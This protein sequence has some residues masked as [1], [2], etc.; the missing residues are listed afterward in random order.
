M[1]VKL[2]KCFWRQSRPCPS[3]Q[4]KWINTEAQAACEVKLIFKS[5]KAMREL[6]DCC[7]KKVGPELKGLENT[8]YEQKKKTQKGWLKTKFSE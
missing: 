5:R 8:A 2:N 4:Q 6:T 3:H 1:N 7:F